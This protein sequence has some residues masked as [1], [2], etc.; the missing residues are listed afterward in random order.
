MELQPMNETTDATA[1]VA[2]LWRYK[3]LVLLVALL[4]A[5]GTYLYYNNRKPFY[6]LATQ[7]NL[8][9]GVEE[10]GL[11]P[12]AV[13]P[14]P[15]RKGKKNAVVS[16]AAAAAAAI[17]SQITH[18]IVVARLHSLNTPAALVAT[19]GTFTAVGAEGALVTIVAQARTPLAAALLANT[20]ADTFVTRENGNDQVGI[21]TALVTARS[22]LSAVELALAT[23]PSATT[24]TS[25]GRKG[26]G[27]SKT[28]DILQEATLK[29]HINQLESQ[30]GVTNVKQLALAHPQS[31]VAVATDPKKNATFAFFIGI[32]LA[33]VAAYTLNAFDRR[34][35]TLAGI[36]SLFPA[37]LLTALP[38]ARHPIVHRDGQ[39]RPA[40]GLNEPLR[41]LQTAL[42]L[43][44]VLNGEPGGRPRSILFLSPDAADGK[45]TVAAGLALVQ[46][47]AGE[48]VSL[49]EADFRRPV[50]ARLL[51]TALTGGLVEVLSGTLTLEE[52]L[53]PVESAVNE[54]REL[55]PAGPQV[56]VATVVKSRGTGTLSVLLG[57]QGVANPPAL[58]A[59]P[60]MAALV[61]SAAEE[62]DHVLI[63]APPPLMVSDVMPL[64]AAVDGIVLVARI[65]HTREASARRLI[66]LLTGMPTAPL[67]GV[68]ANDV[69][70]VDMKR[71]GLS[72]GYPRRGWL[73]RLLGR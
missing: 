19:R 52:A 33:S 32:F 24:R 53:Q 28:S 60:A 4:V 38:S 36:E 17:N 72:P 41:R 57:E 67:L 69:S 31:A 16:P 71:Y 47:D 43:G 40:N 62:F 39:L 26:S 3:W 64:L 12:A 23:N 50:Q 25:N 20:A 6:Q 45:S 63:D 65:G 30:L 11:T 58:L 55:A 10:Q 44:G 1:I 22:Q 7:V 35:R 29:T 14:P 34:V 37:R 51:D 68:V 59:E 48:H 54:R 5:G 42:G 8:A 21:R 2:P 27:T 61:R 70:R 49:I 15:K 73:D 18:G 46:R 13:E 9:N 56:G 66:Q